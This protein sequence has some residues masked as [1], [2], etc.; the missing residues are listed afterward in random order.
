MRTIVT[1]DIAHYKES[2][3]RQN[4]S[5]ASVTSRHCTRFDK[6]ETDCK[7]ETYRN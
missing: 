5:F 3:G 1:Y 6:Q 4:K 2:I 7:F